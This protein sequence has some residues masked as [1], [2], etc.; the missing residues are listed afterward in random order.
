[1][2]GVAVLAVFGRGCTEFGPADPGQGG[3]GVT[4]WTLVRGASGSYHGVVTRVVLSDSGGPTLLATTAGIYQVDRAGVLTSL[5][6]PGLDEYGVELAPD[7]AM[8]SPL[9]PHTEHPGY[10]RASMGILPATPIGA[11][12]TAG[13]DDAVS[14]VVLGSG[15]RFALTERLSTADGDAGPAT[16]RFW[17][18]DA[19]TRVIQSRADVVQPIRMRIALDPTGGSALLYGEP[20]AYAYDARG[21]VRWGLPADHAAVRGCPGGVAGFRKGALSA[22]GGLALLNPAAPAHLSE[23]CVVDTQAPGDIRVRRIVLPV[24]V[25]Q[26]VVSPDGDWAVASGSHGR[27][28]DI[29]IALATMRERPTLTFDPESRD[30]RVADMVL[31]DRD[32]LALGV[33]HRSESASAD[34]RRGSVVVTDRAGAVVLRREVSIDPPAAFVPAIYARYGTR[35]IVAVTPELVSSIPVP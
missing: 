32:R 30:F 24:P 4:G 15:G 8:Y 11:L 19:T 3:G 29:D 33:I 31:V 5:N 26:L 9:V 10:F 13:T 20:G 35:A 6:S 23:V 1:M 34:W 28:F 21:A 22:R 18:I 17:E 27:T 7:G 25:H 14:R 2:A 12:H 16:Y